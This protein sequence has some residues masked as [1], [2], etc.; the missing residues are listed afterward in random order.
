MMLKRFESRSKTSKVVMDSYIEGDNLAFNHTSQKA[1][2]KIFLIIYR[3]ESIKMCDVFEQRI[4]I[5][6]DPTN[7]KDI[8]DLYSVFLSVELWFADYDS[9]EL[10]IF[11]CVY[12]VSY[13]SFIF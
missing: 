2:S 6:F 3:E 9:E 4:F 5:Q 11:I 12:L 13:I 10:V 7:I 8:L 1:C